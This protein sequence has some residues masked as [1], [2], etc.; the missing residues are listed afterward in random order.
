VKG[1]M[2]NVETLTII[3]IRSI[4]HYSSLSNHSVLKLFIALDKPA[5]I[6][7]KLTVMIAITNA[8]LVVMTIPASACLYDLQNFA[9]IYSGAPCYRRSDQH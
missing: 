1:E 7:W 2:A 4:L 5:L 9:A 6:A 3:I 8:R